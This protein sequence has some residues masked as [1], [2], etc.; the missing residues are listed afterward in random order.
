[1][2]QLLIVRHAIAHERDSARWRNDEL[3]PL[4]ARGKRS[5]RRTARRLGDFLDAPD[6]LLTSSLR[7]AMQTARILRDEAGFP[8]PTELRELKPRIPISALIAA[9]AGR[10]CERMAVVGHEPQLSALV[11]QLLAGARSSVNCPLKKGGIALLQF[12]DVIAPERAE[13]LMFVPPRI[14]RN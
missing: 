5:F 2:H 4:T 1:M 6:E 13:L 9:L 7:R 8:K 12:S 14:L 11:S 3:R 10:R